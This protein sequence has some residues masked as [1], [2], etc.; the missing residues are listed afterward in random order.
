MEGEGTM[1]ERAIAD[2]AL[3]RRMFHLIAWSF[4]SCIF[5]EDT[6]TTR[7]F[8]DGPCSGDYYLIET[9]PDGEL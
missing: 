2:P 1:Q 7:K 9:G 4:S 8:P 3:L 6:L 5:M